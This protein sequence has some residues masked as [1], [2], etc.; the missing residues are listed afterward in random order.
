MTSIKSGTASVAAKQKVAANQKE[1]ESKKPFNVFW[2]TTTATFGQTVQIVGVPNIAVNNPALVTVDI[3]FNN[4][5]YVS[6]DSVKFEDGQVKAVWKV[7]ANKTGT[8]TSGVYDAEVRYNGSVPGK[9]NAPL[10]IVS[11]VSAGDFFG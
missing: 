3:L 11:S 8:F 6:A 4:G 5:K 1:T 2:S 7:K 9:T 10:R